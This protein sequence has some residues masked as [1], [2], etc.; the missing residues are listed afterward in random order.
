MVKRSISARRQ[1]GGFRFRDI[2]TMENKKE[3]IGAEVEFKLMDVETLTIP[4]GT[5]WDQAAG[6]YVAPSPPRYK[7][8]LL[9]QYEISDLLGEKQTG[10]IRPDDEW[11]RVGGYDSDLWNQH[12]ASES[13]APSLAEWK[14]GDEWTERPFV[15]IYF[16][17]L[18]AVDRAGAERPEYESPGSGTSADE[19]SS[20]SGGVTLPIAIP[21]NVQELAG[22]DNERIYFNWYLQ[23]KRGEGSA[24]DASI[25]TSELED[26]MAD[27]TKEKFRRILAKARDAKKMEPEPQPDPEPELQP[28]DISQGGEAASEQGGGSRSRRTK[29]RKTRRRQKKT[30]KKYKK[31]H[32]KRQKPRWKNKKTGQSKLGL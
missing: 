3:F 21:N 29:R 16:P 31:K 19:A 6:E 5:L 27:F 7:M 20:L 11:L 30:K 10:F 4:T 2:I 8:D 14:A 15:Y 13:G 12:I 1:K 23:L 9:H 24:L 28:D 22:R 25:D 32:K 26:S 17:D 18:P